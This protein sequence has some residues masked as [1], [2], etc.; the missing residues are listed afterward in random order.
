MIK[1]S[2][3]G[4]MIDRSIRDGLS[5]TDYPPHGDVGG[6]QS[7]ETDDVSDARLISAHKRLDVSTSARSQRK[8]TWGFDWL[9]T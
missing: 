5:E 3:A 1:V 6:E 9:A 8:E 2:V 7:D 4:A